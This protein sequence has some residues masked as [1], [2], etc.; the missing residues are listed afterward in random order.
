MRFVRVQGARLA[1]LAVAAL[2]LASCAQRRA[3]EQPSAAVPPPATEKQAAAPPEQQA[4]QTAEDALAQ[5]Q[6]EQAEQLT[7]L[8]AARQQVVAAQQQLAE[9]QKREDEERAKT[10]E[11]RDRVNQHLQEAQRRAQEAQAAAE[12]AQGLETMAGQVL[13]AT[14]SRVVLQAQGGRTFTFE[15]DQRTTVFVGSE[16]RSVADVQRGADALVAFDPTGD[17]PT[18]RTIRVT[19]ATGQQPPLWDSSGAPQQQ[20]QQQQEQEPR[21]R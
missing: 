13:D 21:A 7:R 5:A 10:L 9:A 16:Q 11:L 12:R 4:T 3:A 14:G 1:W 15:V 20:P 8:E 2:A 18:A 17:Q 19:P 6:R